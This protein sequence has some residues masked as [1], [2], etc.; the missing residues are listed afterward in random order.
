MCEGSIKTRILYKYIQNM[1]TIFCYGCLSFNLILCFY[2]L[3]VPCRSEML[4]DTN[5]TQLGK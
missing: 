4:P 3:K 1:K 5:L 2:F